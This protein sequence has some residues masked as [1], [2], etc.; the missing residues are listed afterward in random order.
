MSKIL[1]EQL[2]IMTNLIKELESKETYYKKLNKEK[3]EVNKFTF[4]IITESQG[5]TGLFLIIND[6]ELSTIKLF[7]DDR[8]DINGICGGEIDE[9]VAIDI[10]KAVVKHTKNTVFF[11][12]F[13]SLIHAFKIGEDGK[14]VDVFSDMLLD[15]NNKK[16][17]LLKDSTQVKIEFE[18]TVGKLYRAPTDKS[19]YLIIRTFDDEKSDNPEVLF[20]NMLKDTSVKEDYHSQLKIS[21]SAIQTVFSV[22]NMHTETRIEYLV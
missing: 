12:I 14:A 16:D 18:I 13:D 7:E 2:I 20:L 4:S 19:L 1:A 8:V 5:E 6:D 17:I 15:L 9:T 10:M 3:E 11:T 21:E 22:I